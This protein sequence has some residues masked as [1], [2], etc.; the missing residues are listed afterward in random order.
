MKSYNQFIEEAYSAKEELNEVLGLRT[1]AKLGARAIPGLQT[2]YGL[3][4]GAYRLSKGDRL[5]AGLAAASAIPGPIGW[6]AL[7]ADVARELSP[8]S[9]KTAPTPTPKPSPTSSSP[10]PSSTLPPTSPSS[11]KPSTVLAKKGGVEG[12]LDKSTG[13]FTTKSF[14]DIER[15]RYETTRGTQKLNRDSQLIKPQTV[16]SRIRQAGQEYGKKAFGMK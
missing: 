1:A 7:G 13:K 15:K 6:A 11:P 2:A 14:S 16:G 8:K 3:G 12:T 10:K 4:L 5:G 9:A